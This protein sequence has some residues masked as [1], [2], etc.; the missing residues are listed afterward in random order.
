M[1]KPIKP[2]KP[3]KPIQERVYNSLQY[4]IRSGHIDFSEMF[5]TLCITDIKDIDFTKLSMSLDLDYDTY[6]STTEIYGSIVYRKEYIEQIDS[7]TYKKEMTKYKKKMLEYNVKLNTYSKK[8]KEYDAEIIKRKNV[9]KR[10]Q[11]EK[12]K[13]EYGE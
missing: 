3:T 9:E 7:N 2:K 5:E 1:R 8:I 12:L 11:Y 4:K 13:K 10:T 6:D